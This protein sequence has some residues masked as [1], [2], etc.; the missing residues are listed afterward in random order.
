METN[1]LSSQQ[2]EQAI[3][4]NI[5][6]EFTLF[7]SS[8]LQTDGALNKVNKAHEKVNDREAT[9]EPFTVKAGGRLLE[10][11]NFSIEQ[12]EGE[13]KSVFDDVELS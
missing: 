6:Q 2:K 4:E 12:M 5:H 11:Y 13:N 10:M 8:K 1:M 9:N 7:Y 3:W